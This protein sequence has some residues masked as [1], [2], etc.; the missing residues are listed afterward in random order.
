[1]Y[2]DNV[3]EIQNYGGYGQSG[4]GYGQSG[5][6]YGQTNPYEQ[7]GGRYNQSAG[8]P[9]A[10][11]E[12]NPYAQQ[13]PPPQPSYGGGRTQ[14]SRPEQGGYD[15]RYGGGRPQ[16]PAT[17]GPQYG[18]DESSTK[19]LLWL[20]SVGGGN[21]M[22]MGP[23]NGQTGGTYGAAP[24]RDP[25]AMLNDCRDIDK[26][27]DTIEQNL[28]KL[29]FY[30]Q[31]SLDDPDASQSTMKNRELD[32]L[33][34]DTMTLY[35]DLAYRIKVMKQKKESGDPRNKP[36]VGLVDR[37]L[38]KAINEYQQ[39]DRDFRHKLSAQMERQYR[40]VR[41]DASDQEVREAIEDTSNN[42]VFSQAV[43]T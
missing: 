2:A 4:G 41:P 6:G 36:Q 20:T 7:E 5:G 11:Q 3:F 15:N 43:S 18:T 17:S 13:P 12:G 23:M 1:M 9:Y 24:T 34:T 22:E 35:R 26:K 38:K 37:K 27:I 21:E 28:D 39:I 25:N 31:R 42:Q 8:N 30:Q 29:R 40:I 32:A 16:A 14:Q 10:Q 33:S 19:D